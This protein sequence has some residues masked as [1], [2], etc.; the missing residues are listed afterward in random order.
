MD[1]PKE[2]GW[3]FGRRRRIT[4]HGQI[5]EDKTDWNMWRNLVF[6]EAKLLQS[7]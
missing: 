7:G 5:E 6:V 4:K 3:M 2:A 1:D